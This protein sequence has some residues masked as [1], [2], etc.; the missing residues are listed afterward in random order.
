MWPKSSIKNAKNAKSAKLDGGE[1]NKKW[2]GETQT[3]EYFNGSVLPTLGLK[4]CPPLAV[5]TKANQRLE[6][7]NASLP[8]KNL[9]ERFGGGWVFCE[10]P[11]LRQNSVDKKEMARK[12]GRQVAFSFCLCEPYVHLTSI[13]TRMK[14]TL[15]EKVGA[16]SPHK[17]SPGGRTKPSR[18]SPSFN[19]SHFVN[20]QFKLNRCAVPFKNIPDSLQPLCH[21]L[22]VPSTTIPGSIVFTPPHLALGSSSH[23]AFT[24]QLQDVNADL[25]TYLRQNAKT[26]KLNSRY[27]L[28]HRPMRASKVPASIC[29]PFF[30]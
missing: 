5:S 10:I 16:K 7:L 2:L 29:V 22:V 14:P 11:R 30:N 21:W 17:T 9:E 18:S 1:T 12:D 4:F 27:H 19:P 28:E 15:P 3:K 26:A 8:L 6:Y 23:I 24:M 20:R 13:S 25:A